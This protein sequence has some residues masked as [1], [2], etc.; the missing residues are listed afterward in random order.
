MI[1]PTDKSLSFVGE[2]KEKTI[3]KSANGLS[4]SC[5]Y[6]SDSSSTQA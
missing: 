2:D 6:Q 5:F 3:L 1:L 4:E